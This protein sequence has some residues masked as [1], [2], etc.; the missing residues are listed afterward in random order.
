MFIYI[1]DGVLCT[2]ME[3]VVLMGLRVTCDLEDGSLESYKS[4]V[5][6]FCCSARVNSIPTYDIRHILLINH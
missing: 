4:R 6:S 3:C 5:E 1:S 2:Y